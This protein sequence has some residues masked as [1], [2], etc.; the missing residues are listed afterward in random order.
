[1]AGKP[2]VDDVLSVAKTA[3]VYNDVFL[4]AFFLRIAQEVIQD[5][6]QNVS[7]VVALCRT[8]MNKTVP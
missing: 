7:G 6:A 8:I 2:L 5:V 4:L 3:I 1:V